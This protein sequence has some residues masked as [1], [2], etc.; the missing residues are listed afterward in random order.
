MMETT[1]TSETSVDI[2]LTTRQYIP[3]DSGL[4]VWKIFMGQRQIGVW[5][6]PFDFSSVTL[7]YKPM[8][9]FISRFTAVVSYDICDS[10]MSGKT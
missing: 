5:N 1:R 6:K 10:V 4:K 3:E 8:R 2:D 7:L 9:P